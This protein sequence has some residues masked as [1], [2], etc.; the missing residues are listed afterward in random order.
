MYIFIF[1]VILFLCLILFQCLN[2]SFTSNIEEYFNPRTYFILEF[3]F[4]I[5]MI[6]ICWEYVKFSILNFSI[7][8]FNFSNLFDYSIS[9][10]FKISL[11][12]T[13]FFNF[14]KASFKQWIYQYGIEIGNMEKIEEVC[15][16]LNQRKLLV[17][18]FNW[19]IVTQQ[20]LLIKP[21]LLSMQQ[22][23]LRRFVQILFLF[24]ICS[25]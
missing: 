25:S 10:Y 21:L 24:H 2:K 23:H 16:K 17:L 19:R 7:F 15:R 8:H 12:N 4:V 13:W 5:L 22:K 9:K 20:D 18:F 6:F 1:E 14:P 11:S 3:L